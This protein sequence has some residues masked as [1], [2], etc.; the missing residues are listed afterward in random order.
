MTAPDDF[1]DLRLSAAS[2]FV[3]AL[4][5]EFDEVR[6]NLVLGHIVLGPR[7]HDAWGVVHPGVYSTVVERAASV[8]ASRAVQGTG[9]FAVGIHNATHVFVSAPAGHAHVRAVP[10]LQADDQQIWQVAVTC[11]GSL[12]AHGE[13]RLQNVPRPAGG[14]DAEPGPRGPAVLDTRRQGEG[15]IGRAARVVGPA[16]L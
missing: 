15:T 6:G 10:L 13:L 7:H 8:G 11:A 2:R 9:R 16:N 1:P 5:L 4:G 14:A 3:A 12:L